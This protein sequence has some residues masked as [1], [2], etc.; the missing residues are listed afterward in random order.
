MEAPYSYIATPTIVGRKDIP[1][2]GSLLP[3]SGG[4]ISFVVHA[5]NVRIGVTNSRASVRVIIT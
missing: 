3:I 1:Q 5:P 4:P 2:V